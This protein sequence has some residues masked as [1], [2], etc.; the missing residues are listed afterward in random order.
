MFCFCCDQVQIELEVN[1]LETC[2]A[3]EARGDLY[4]PLKELVYLL[5]SKDVKSHTLQ[6][7]HCLLP[8]PAV[9]FL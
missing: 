3:H 9:V 5:L 7:T 6:V 1:N 2:M 4:S 8:M